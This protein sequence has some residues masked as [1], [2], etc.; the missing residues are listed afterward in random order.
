MFRAAIWWSWCFSTL[1]HCFIQDWSVCVAVYL[2]ACH[3]VSLEYETFAISS[4]QN[5]EYVSPHQRTFNCGLLLFLSKFKLETD[6]NLDKTLEIQAFNWSSCS[7]LTVE[8]AVNYQTKLMDSFLAVAAFRPMVFHL[9]QAKQK[10]KNYRDQGR[11]TLFAPPH[12]TPLHRIALLFDI[13][14]GGYFPTNDVVLACFKAFFA[15]LANISFF[16]RSL[17]SL[18]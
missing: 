1:M 10:W 12:Q 3:H 2:L 16:F 7:V 18:Q 9:A 6:W 11:L 5:G 15:W 14:Y 8:P 17:N 4:R 13:Q